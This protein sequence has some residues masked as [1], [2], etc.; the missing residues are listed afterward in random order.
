MG[1]RKRGRGGRGRGIET[2]SESQAE[3]TFAQAG[4]QLLADKE[5]EHA[6]NWPLPKRRRTPLKPPLFQAQCP[7]AGCAQ[8]SLC[9]ELWCDFRPVLLTL[10]EGFRSL[11]YRTGSRGAQRGGICLYFIR[12]QTMDLKLECFESLCSSA[13]AIEKLLQESFKISF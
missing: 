12:G 5:Q 4:P 8:S 13:L 2:S 9:Q 11:F 1:G 6:D 7:D 3:V 10:K